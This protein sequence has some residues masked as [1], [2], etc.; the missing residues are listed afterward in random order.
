MGGK[1]HNAAIGGGSPKK[2]VNAPQFKIQSPQ[3]N[4]SSAKEPP[5]EES[6]VEEIKSPSTTIMPPGISLDTNY[7]I[8]LEN[9]KPK[10]LTHRQITIRLPM[11]LDDDINR[12]CQSKKGLKQ[13]LIMR[14]IEREITLIKNLK[15]EK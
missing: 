5:A 11:E 2:K 6:I 14:A 7:F 3:I 8:E 4:D 1:G 10:Y 13:E 12:L 9:K 15:N